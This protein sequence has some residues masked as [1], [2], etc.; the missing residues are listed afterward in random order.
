MTISNTIEDRIL[1]L[2]AQK[3]RIVDAALGEGGVKGQLRLNLNDLMRLF[4]MEG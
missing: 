4:E 2:Q 3:Q 1:D